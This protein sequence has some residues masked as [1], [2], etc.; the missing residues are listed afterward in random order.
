MPGA[1][2]SRATGQAI[3]GYGTRDK[4]HNGSTDHQQGN[5]DQTTMRVAVL[6]A[7]DDVAKRKTEEATACKSGGKQ[8][9]DRHELFQQAHV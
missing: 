2:K 9:Q 1:F 7:G 3:C 6:V 8:A 5:K 4:T